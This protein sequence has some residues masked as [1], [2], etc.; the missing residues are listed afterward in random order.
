MRKNTFGFAVLAATASLG[1]GLVVSGCGDS[2]STTL[3]P[4]GPQKANGQ[5]IFDYNILSKSLAK[6]DV[7]AKIATVKYAFS[8]TNAEKEAFTDI[9]DAYAYTFEHKSEAY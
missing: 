5:V 4:L 1:L 9:K 6:T 2:G 8:G 3:N 7:D